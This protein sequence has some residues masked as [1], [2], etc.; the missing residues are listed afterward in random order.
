MKGTFPVHSASQGSRLTT[1]LIGS[2]KAIDAP[3]REDHNGASEGEDDQTLDSDD[4]GHSDAPPANGGAASS[5]SSR[6]DGCSTDGVGTAAIACPPST[7][8]TVDVRDSQVVLVL[9]KTDA[10]VV[11]GKC[12]VLT[13]PRLALIGYRTHLTIQ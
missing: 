3:L 12:G 1:E 9:P 13:Q 8:S 11:C 4:R 10:T 6:V 5:S 2:R 7:A